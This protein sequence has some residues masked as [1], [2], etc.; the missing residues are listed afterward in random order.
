VSARSQIVELR[1][2]TVALLLAIVTA[3]SRI[4]FATQRLWEWDS[5]LYARALEQGFHVDD[6]LS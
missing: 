4:P 6:V 5:V 3:L 1:D 2:P